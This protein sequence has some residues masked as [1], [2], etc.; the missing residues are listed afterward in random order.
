MTTMTLTEE[1]ALFDLELRIVPLDQKDD[2]NRNL[3]ASGGCVHTSFVS[4][5]C[6]RTCSA[7]YACSYTCRGRAA[8]ES[9]SPNMCI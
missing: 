6:T 9:A 8:H 7:T 3:N 4:E 1:D 2:Y 5:G